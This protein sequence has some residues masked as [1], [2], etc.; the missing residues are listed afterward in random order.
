MPLCFCRG[1]ASL[2]L[3]SLIHHVT[4]GHELDERNKAGGR[5]SAIGGEEVDLSPC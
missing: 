2:P 1:Q 4:E 5:S 3:E